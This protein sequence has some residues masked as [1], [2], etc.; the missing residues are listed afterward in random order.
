MH[1]SLLLP[2]VLLLLPSTLANPAPMKFCPSP[3]PY[4][5]PTLFPN[6]HQSTPSAPSTPPP[7]P[8]PQIPPSY[9]TPT[10]SS[11][12]TAPSSATHLFAKKDHRGV[13]RARILMASRSVCRLE[14]SVVGTGGWFWSAVSNCL[15]KGGK[16]LG[17]RDIGK[18]VCL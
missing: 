16:H 18:G 5:F 7:P 15:S 9:T 12:A 6:S 8:L 14:E 13:R 11:P 2:T 10:P 17:N 4:P 3:F 1:L